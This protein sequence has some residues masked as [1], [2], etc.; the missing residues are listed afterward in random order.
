MTQCRK[1]GRNA[2][3]DTTPLAISGWQ[4]VL[5]AVLAMLVA[6]IYG[7]LRARDAVRRHS[8]HPSP[9]PPRRDEQQEDEDTVKITC[10]TLETRR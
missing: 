6:V 10:R 7:E 8:V 2:M 9:R 1:S 5:L 4:T 3:C